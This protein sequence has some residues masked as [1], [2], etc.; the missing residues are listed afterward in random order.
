MAVSTKEQLRCSV[1]QLG[2]MS[3]RH[4]GAPTAGVGGLV[5]DGFR[6]GSSS[7]F[8]YRKPCDHGKH[9][10]PKAVECYLFMAVLWQCFSYGFPFY[11][12][13][14]K[15]NITITTTILGLLRQKTQLFK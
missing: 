8:A 12:N 15:L 4:Q 3:R 2:E 5:S 13:N 6:S 7:E 11:I 1:L 14:L 9:T 10:V